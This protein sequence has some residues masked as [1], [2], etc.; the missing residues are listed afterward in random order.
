VPNLN[1]FMTSSVP[2]KYVL[3]S[4]VGSDFASAF[5]VL[6]VVALFAAMVILQLTGARILWAQARDGQLPAAKALKKVSAVHKIPVNATIVAFVIPVL[7]AFWS[8]AL[9]EVVSLTALTWA[10][11]YGVAVI[12]GL[13]AIARGQL[14]LGPF[15]LGVLTV[16][17]FILAAVWSVVICTVIVWSDPRHVGVAMIWAIAIGFAIYF[18]IP[19]SRRGRVPGVHDEVAPL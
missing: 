15:R 10:A 9:T 19:S 5:E 2:V 16:P 3:A 13:Y 14:P 4:A 17:V 18:T 6:A 11:A 12:A 7:L 8:S 1:T